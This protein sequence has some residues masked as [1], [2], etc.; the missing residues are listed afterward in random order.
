MALL[1]P[2]IFPFVGRAVV[3][4]ERVGWVGWWDRAVSLED[5]NILSSF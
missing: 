5:R 1:M 4:S 3:F 2:S